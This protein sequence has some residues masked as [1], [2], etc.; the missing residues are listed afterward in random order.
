MSQPKAAD[1]KKRV[2]KLAGN[3]WDTNA[4]Q[5][6]AEIIERHGFTEFRPTITMLL[7]SAE[8]TSLEIA[9]FGR[10]SSGKSSLLNHVIGADLLPVGVTPITAVPTRI[11][12]GQKPL[13]RVW[14]EGLGISEHP[15]DELPMFV[16]ERQNPENQK[17]VGRILV[18]FPSERLR[19]G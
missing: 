10:V 4:L 19:E 12:Y 9:V 5:L 8:D 17:R 2:R 16:D 1:L 15:V 3:G 6:L 11:G 13:V 14:R 18:L 7:D